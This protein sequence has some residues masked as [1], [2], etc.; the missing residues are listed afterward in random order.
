MF[1]V[2]PLV[3]APTS[4]YGLPAGSVA[5]VGPL[6][7]TAAAPAAKLYRTTATEL[8]SEPVLLVSATGWLYFP[9]LRLKE[10]TPSVTVKCA[11]RLG[12]EPPPSPV[13]VSEKF[14]VVNP[15]AAAVTV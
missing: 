14:T 7:V 1:A 10:I 6:G 9:V 8:W 12:A 4:I 5:V 2:P 13:L 11:V 15:L 3:I